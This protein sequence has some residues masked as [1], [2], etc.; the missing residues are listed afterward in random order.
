MTIDTSTR[1]NQVKEHLLGYIN[2]NQMTEGDQLPSEAEMAKAIGVSRNTIR[3]AYISLEAEGIIIRR[4]GIGTFVARS[5]I[6]TDPL[7]GE[8]S[9]FISRISSAG[10]TPDIQNLSITHSIAPPDVYEIL[11]APRSEKLLCVKRVIL[12]NETPAVYIIDYYA[13]GIKQSDFNWDTFDGDMIQLVTV[14]LGISERQMYS[15]IH[16]I[17]PDEEIASYLQLSEGQP[18]INIR[19]TVTTLN[20]QEIG[21]SIAYLNPNIIELDAIRFI[22]SK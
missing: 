14:S 6:I 16:A 19:S 10:Y 15:R 1:S 22:R 17:I 8:V 3:E 11:D 4:H 12:A 20:N 9:G 21:Y 5:P 18:I 7:V 2:R 13:S